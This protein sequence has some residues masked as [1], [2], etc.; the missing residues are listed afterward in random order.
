MKI[1]IISSHFENLS[2][3]SVHPYETDQLC[4][5]LKRNRIEFELID[6]KKI[7][8]GIVDNVAY[9]RFK[10]IDENE[11]SVE[12]LDILLVRRTRDYEE[13]ILDFVEYALKA[14]PNLLI[15]DPLDSFHRP[16]SKVTSII[17]RAGVFSQP[18]TQVISYLSDI[19]DEIQYPLILKPS[20][21]YKGE[22]VTGCSSA[23]ELKAYLS[24]HLENDTSL[25]YGVLA[26]QRLDTEHEYRVVVVGG[27][28]VGCVKKVPA[29]DNQIALN[30]TEG[31]TFENYE[32]LNRK[33]IEALAENVSTHSGLSFS[34]VDI[35]EASGSL[36]ILECNRNPQFAAFDNATGVCVA[37][38]IVEHCIEKYQERSL[39]NGGAPIEIQETAPSYLPSLFIG[40][41]TES[42][43]I[44]EVIQQSL[45]HD[46]ETTIWTQGVFEPAKVGFN[47]LV[48]KV[49]EFDLAVF[50]LSPDDLV[51]TRGD[52]I[53]Q[54]RDNVLFEIGLFM[55]VLGSDKVFLVVN[56]KDK[57]KMPSD[58]DGLTT[59]N[60]LPHK[61]G[62]LKAALG[63]ACTEIKQLI[64]KMR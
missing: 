58:F 14:D 31:A 57:P 10:G 15:L 39:V 54:P 24:E 27:K 60:W 46:A 16:T 19:I 64:R 34:G 37:D 28:S 51:L 13:I 11:H 26:Q 59:I 23:D 38:R 63:S 22:D 49:K 45:I 48:E 40:S 33:N 25:G 3:T 20:H 32:G 53:S 1:G 12:E 52:S 56:S 55:G 43:E 8:Y 18:D 47:S 30:A 41:S 62:N 2:R 50:P 6:V 61:S 4:A 9:C 5:S 7:T 21:G 35:V 29:H 36:Y 17:G 42:L 44:A